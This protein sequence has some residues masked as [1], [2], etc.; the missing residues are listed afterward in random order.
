MSAARVTAYIDAAPPEQQ[1]TLRD[2]RRRL[3]H[4]LGAVTKEALGA[5]GFPVLV[6][7]GVWVA[8]FA[9]RKKGAMLYVMNAGLL[10]GYDERLGR[11][12]SG[13]SCIEWRETKQLSLDALGSLVDE[14]LGEEA[15]RLGR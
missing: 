14:I 10:D 5:S 12:R 3:G 11:L 4:H 6:V 13:R 8:G 9:W 15:R 2:L 1:A 7:D